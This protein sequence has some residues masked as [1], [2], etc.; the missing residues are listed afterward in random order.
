[1][2]GIFNCRSSPL[3]WGIANA[4]FRA[5]AKLLNITPENDISLIKINQ[6]KFKSSP[7]DLVTIK[8]YYGKDASNN[9]LPEGYD[10]VN[11][12]KLLLN[13]LPQHL[14]VSR[15]YYY[16]YCPL[17]TTVLKADL[18]LFN[19]YFNRFILTEVTL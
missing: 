16:E 7:I 12:A 8:G 19:L 3:L 4:H 18:N 17:A 10:C 15:T 5:V 11:I 1:M 2:T 9:I 6:A 13:K 14:V